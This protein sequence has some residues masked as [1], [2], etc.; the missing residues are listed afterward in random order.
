[1]ALEIRLADASLEEPLMKR[2]EELP[3]VRRVKVERPE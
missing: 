2:L 3:S 1:M